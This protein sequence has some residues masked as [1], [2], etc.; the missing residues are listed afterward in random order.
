ITSSITDDIKIGDY[1]ILEIDR[2]IDYGEVI[3]INETEA[4]NYELKN[5][6]RKATPDDLK[7][8]KKNK[9]E[10]K[11]AIKTCIAKAKEHK[12]S[13]KLIDAEY[14]FDKKKIVFYFVSDER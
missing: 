2:G 12:L 8:I 4:I 10:A 13:I 6:L 5:I 3:E 9:Q 11:D 1:V 14:S 7:Q